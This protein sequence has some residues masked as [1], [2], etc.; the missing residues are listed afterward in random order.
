MNR[1]FRQENSREVS[2][3]IFLKCLSWYAAHFRPGLSLTASLRSSGAGKKQIIAPYLWQN[4]RAEEP[5]QK[6]AL[7]YEMYTDR[8]QHH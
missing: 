4:L 2:P 3:E 1:S 8:G 5:H 7:D 6:V